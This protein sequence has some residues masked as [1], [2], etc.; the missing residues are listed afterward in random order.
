MES[1]LGGIHIVTELVLD[2]NEK[3]YAHSYKY[4]SKKVIWFIS[5][6]GTW[7]TKPGKARE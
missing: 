7:R 3:L 1:L 4:K 6:E 2:N 5:S